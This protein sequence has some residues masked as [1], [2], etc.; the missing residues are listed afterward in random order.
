[1]LAAGAL[2]TD[3]FKPLL[4]NPK[5]EIEGK[6][7]GVPYR[8]RVIIPQYHTRI[9]WH[10]RDIAQ[11]TPHSAP[12]A[13]PSPFEQFGLQLRFAQVAEIALH[14]RDM[15]LDASIRELVAWFG[16]VL[17]HNAVIAGG[18]RA[19]YHRNI[20]P[21]L[22]FHTD[23][24]P[25]M[26]NRYSCFTRDPH[27]AEQRP[28]RASST[29]FIANCV[30]W[31]EGVRDGQIDPAKEG[32][33]PMNIDLFSNG[34]ITDLLGSIVLEQPWCEPDGT[35][36]IAVIDNATVLHATYHK[37]ERVKGYPI[38]ARYLS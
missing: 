38:G 19:R 33:T 30:A 15:V 11:K 28:P 26:P 21:H 24:A 31:L 16:P 36:E 37:V 12:P 8:A 13:M 35:A 20:F 2:D 29:L 27:D 1:L 4:L 5:I 10:Y 7:P 14:D 3:L 25:D 18:A 22:R 6:L 23:R 32:G 34:A 17:L 9:L